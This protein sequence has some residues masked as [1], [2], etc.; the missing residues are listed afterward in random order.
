[1]SCKQ[2]QVDI[3]VASSSYGEE[4][5]ITV[6]CPPNIPC[7]QMGVCVFTAAC[8]LLCDVRGIKITIN[9][10]GTPSMFRTYSLNNGPYQQDNVFYVATLPPQGYVIK[11]YDREYLCL[12]QINTG[13]LQC[14]QRE[15]PESTFVRNYIKNYYC[16]NTSVVFAYETI[17]VY[18]AGGV[19]Y[20]VITSRII[21]S[22]C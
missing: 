19:E 7:G 21:L 16:P 20:D 18:Q 13:Y 17:D 3:N 4:Q 14:N 1:M 5:I 10:S 8:E 22:P 9:T 11:I 15:R 12:K 6:P 2:V